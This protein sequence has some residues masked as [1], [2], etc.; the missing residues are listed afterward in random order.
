MADP[1]RL[2]AG[3]VPRVL[4][5]W[6]RP[7]RVMRDLSPMSEG[8]LLATLMGAMLVFLIAQTPGHA[9]AAALDPSVPLAGRMAGAVMA[10]IFLLPLLAYAVAALVSFAMRLA[11]RPVAPEDSRLA[12]FWSLLAISPAMLLGGLTEGLAGPGPALTLVR[13]VTGIGFIVI[14]GAGLK[15]LGGR[16]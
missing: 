9:R 15:A 8:A 14:W 1:A 5:S 7:G 13:V 2:R 4:A 6:R 16:A 11:G 3:I 12:L 10:V